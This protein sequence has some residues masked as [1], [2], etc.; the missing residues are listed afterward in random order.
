MVKKIVHL[1]MVWCLIAT[2]N[3]KSQPDISE[4]TSTESLEVLLEAIESSNAEIAQK[5]LEI[6]DSQEVIEHA[7]ARALEILEARK[8]RVKIPVKL[9]SIKK[10]SEKIALF[11]KFYDKCMQ[12]VI[13]L[14]EIPEDKTEQFIQLISATEHPEWSASRLMAVGTVLTAAVVGN[15]CKMIAAQFQQEIDDLEFAQS[16]VDL[17]ESENS[18]LVIKD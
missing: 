15:K 9:E 16:V 7:Y 18:A 14:L 13:P 3:L 17:F 6:I 12:K 2:F 1:L 4:Q 11:G 10:F 5:M 8:K